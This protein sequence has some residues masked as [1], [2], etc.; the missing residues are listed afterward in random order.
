MWQFPHCLGA[1]DGKHV[2][3]T[4]PHDAGSFFFNY[5]EFHS[6]VLL[7]VVNAKYEF[8][9]CDFGTNGRISDGGVIE[10]TKFG[11]KLNNNSLRIPPADILPPFPTPLP[12]VFVGDEAFAL[13]ENFLKPYNQRELNEEKKIFNYRLSRAR[14][15]VENTFGILCSKFRIF[16]SPINLK[17]D[18][19]D[20]VVMASCVLH[21]FLRR[22]T[23]NTRHEAPDI[24]NDEVRQQEVLPIAELERGH[25]RRC[26]EVAKGVRDTFMEYFIGEGAV[27]WQKE[28]ICK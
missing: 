3:I 13:K 12:Y 7:A 27:P 26:C 1:V 4:P 14:R 23:N 15:V 2:A 17:P 11:E 20:S 25:N 19:I 28:K 16:E 21:N 18:N 24:L 10:N 9:M 8:I 5:K 6:L 22:N